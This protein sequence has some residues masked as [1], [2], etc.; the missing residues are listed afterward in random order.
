MSSCTISSVDG[1]INV[2]FGQGSL[3]G[4]SIASEIFRL[5]YSVVTQLDEGKERRSIADLV[6]GEQDAG[7]WRDVN[8]CG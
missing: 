4:D 7:R 8:L 2:S 1:D 6:P 3:P 5:V